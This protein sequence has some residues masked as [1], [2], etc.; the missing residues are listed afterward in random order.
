M[1]R[2]D[3]MANFSGKRVLVVG[4]ETK[5]GRALVVALAEAGADV[6]IVSLSKDTKAEFAINSALNELWALGRKGTALTIDASSGEQ[7]GDAIASAERE[8]GPIDLVAVVSE[9]AP[10]AIDALAGRK[11]VE[12]AAGATISEALAAIEAAL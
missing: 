11:V 8:L 12:V 6:A 2:S 7:V 10:V 9:G 1:E 5:L 3:Q 4:G